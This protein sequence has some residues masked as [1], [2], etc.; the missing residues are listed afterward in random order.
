VSFIPY[1]SYHQVKVGDEMFNFYGTN[2]FDH[3][4]EEKEGQ[5]GQE[6]EGAKKGKKGGKG[7]AEE[8]QTDSQRMTPGMP[9][10]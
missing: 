8:S 4:S 1:T 3:F 6:G 7:E 10:L 2:W 9:I 5:E